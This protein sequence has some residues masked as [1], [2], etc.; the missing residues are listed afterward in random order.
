MTYY[1]LGKAGKITPPTAPVSPIISIAAMETVNE[2]DESHGSQTSK[3]DDKTVIESS[4]LNADSEGITSD[5][6]FNSKEVDPLLQS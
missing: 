2:E 3:S 6:I 1:L 5:P 4:D